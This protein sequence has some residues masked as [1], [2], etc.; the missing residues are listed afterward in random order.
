MNN[1]VMKFAQSEVDPCIF[2]H[3]SD[4][5][6]MYLIVY[7]DDC[8]YFGSN[9]EVEKQFEDC[10]GERFQLE[11]LGH[12]HW[13]LGTRLYREADGSYIIDQETYS[14]HIL[15]RYC[16]PDSP[17]G[18]PPMQS[19]P[20][21]SDYVYSKKN[22]PNEEE[23]KIISE[24][25]KG[26]AMASAV[27]SLLYVALNTRSDIL[28][29]VNKLAKS[30]SNPGIRD[31]Q[32]LMHCFGYLRQYPD[33]AIKYYA[34]VKQSPVYEICKQNNIEYTPILGFTDSSWQDCPDTGRS[35]CGFK[36]FIQ[37][38]I[39]EANS[40]MPVPVA[41]SSAEAEY[42]GSCNLGA[43]ICH[44]RDLQYDLKY[45]GSPEYNLQE[46]Y[47]TPPSI[48]LVDNSATIAMSENYKVT[49]K[50]RHI[51]RR[52]HFVRWGVKDKLFKLCWIP[53]KDQ[54]ADDT[55]KT[56]EAKKSQPHFLRTLIK[57]PDKVKGYRGNKIG[58]R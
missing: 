38:G 26:L 42:M 55:T 5:G 58:N 56:Q 21:P 30:S 31:Y 33:Y 9:D 46:T 43:I 11:I 8:L 20:A 22:R 47:G 40:T 48:M 52:W 24:R 39:I 44:Y 35:T 4:L 28:W 17:W 10:L 6:T 54:L 51:A 49:K 3:R 13:F 45:L 57:I 34:D 23:K 1:D 2:I 14:K 27:S 25:Y 50:N 41:L 37:G 53:G 18:L 29:I 32:A 7:I 36:I 12:A 19:T 16:G 15:N